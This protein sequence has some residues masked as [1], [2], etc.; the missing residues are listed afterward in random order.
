MMGGEEP[1]TH[2]FEV[3]SGVVHTTYGCGEFDLKGGVVPTTN[4]C[5]EF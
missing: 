3:K 5:G 2:R 4:G 1:A